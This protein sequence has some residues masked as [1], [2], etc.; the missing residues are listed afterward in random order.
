M[1]IWL[2]KVD[3]IVKLKY[4]CINEKVKLI[5]SLVISAPI[6]VTPLLANSCNAKNDGNKSKFPVINPDATFAAKYYV[7]ALAKTLKT[8][9]DSISSSVTALAPKANNTLDITSQINT[10][11][12]NAKKNV[13]TESDLIDE[14]TISF[15]RTGNLK[16]EKNTDNKDILTVY[17]TFINSSSTQ[18]TLTTTLSLTISSNDKNT[19]TITNNYNVAKGFKNYTKGLPNAEVGAVQISNDGGTIYVETTEGVS[20]GTKNNDTWNFKNYK[21]GLSSN[22]VKW[23]YPFNNGNTI[24][25]GSLGIVGDQVG[26]LSVGTK[27]GNTYTFKNYSTATG[28]IDNDVISV[29]PSSDGNT[30]A[31]G[32]VNG[33]SMGTKQSDGSY[34]F[35]NYNES[36]GLGNDEIESTY[37][38]SDGNNVYVGTFDGVSIGTKN[39]DT[40]TFKNYT[41]GLKVVVISAV[42]PRNN[43]NTL[44]VGTEG[45]G[46]A[47][48]TKSNDTYTFKNYP[49]GAGQGSNAILGLYVNKDA[50]TIYAATAYNSFAS[51]PHPGGVSVGIKKADGSY[52]FSYYTAGLGSTETEPITASSD[53]NTVY[54]GTV[55]GL[56]VSSSNWINQSIIHYSQ[57]NHQAIVLNNKNNN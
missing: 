21:T 46:L 54:V 22:A 55:K 20:V 51:H 18:Q 44:Y 17:P 3:K 26:G 16:V 9:L 40:W 48:G 2:G 28:L 24:F 56:S 36:D 50:S 41:E 29:Y 4:I 27:N 19:Q 37:L 32:T 47:V 25:V 14:I 52:A 35:K 45:S 8:Q 42:Y 5:K 31:V 12:A 53:G 43:G 11:R 39:G 15:Q 49:V 10:A 57:N 1:I 30:I 34:T 33:V 38:T 23:V 13:K 7:D 6:I